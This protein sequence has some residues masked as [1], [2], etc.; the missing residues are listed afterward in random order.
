MLVA[1]AS[2]MA[3]YFAVA[4]FNDTKNMKNQSNKKFLWIIFIITIISM[5]FAANYFYKSSISTAEPYAPNIY[6]QQWQ[7]AMS[8]V[9]ENSPETAVFAHWWDYG[10]WVQSIGERATV[11]DG[12]N[13]IP[14]WNYLMGRYALTGSDSL[15]T[16]RFFY[17]HNVTHFLI[18]SSDIG[19][20]PAFSSIGSD[21][22]YDRYS[23]ISSFVLDESQS[24]ERKNSTL[25]FYSGGVNI[26]EDIIYDLNGTRV[27]IPANKAGLGAILIE[28][29]SLG[30]IVS[31]PEGIFVYQSNQY[32]LPLRY[33]FDS[34]FHDFGMG[35]KSGV[36]LMPS[37]SQSQNGIDIKTNG[38]LLYLSN[39]TV[40]SQLARLYL[41]K[42][43]DSYFKLAHSEDDFVV[44]QIK[45]QQPLSSDFIFFN[46]IRGPIRIWEI[47]YPEGLEVNPVFLQ[48]SY[49]NPELANS[50]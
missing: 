21:A 14:Y 46:G 40:K 1:P 29:D 47:N 2:I 12:G 13:T 25:F 37:L 38:A 7:K 42:E 28:Q 27:F 39:R 9:R 22:S 18:D 45:A 41:Y 11:L 36:F 23:W 34:S 8:W 16:I 31:Q 49:P 30:N 33:A 5:L 4:L 43:N 44:S 32:K 26:D 20:Y 35:V 50:R 19:K 17:S 6:T 24:Q 3:S 15:E 10:Y 48:K